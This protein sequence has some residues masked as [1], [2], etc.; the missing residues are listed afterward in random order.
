[1]SLLEYLQGRIVLALFIFLSKNRKPQRFQCFC[2]IAT[3]VVNRSVQGVV[4]KAE[5]DHKSTKQLINQVTPCLSS[6]HPEVVSK[7]SISVAVEDVPTAPV[8]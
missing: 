6:R 5:K 1:M 4:Y 2:S 8:L 3:G 7:Q